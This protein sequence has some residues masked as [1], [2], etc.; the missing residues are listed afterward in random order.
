MSKEKTITNKIIDRLRLVP[1]SFVMKVHGGPMQMAGVPDVLFI[2]KGNTMWFEVKQPG[3][4]PTRIQEHRMKELARAGSY[5]FVVTS[6]QEA[7]AA[8]KQLE[9]ID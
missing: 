9:I 5:P 8:L 1:D 7:E 6:V 2:C 4:Q 3:K